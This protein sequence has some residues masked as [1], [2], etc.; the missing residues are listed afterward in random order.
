M[1]GRRLSG[2]WGRGPEVLAS[3]L[4]RLGAL[5][6]RPLGLGSQGVGALVGGVLGLGAL[7][8]AGA[9]SAWA[10]DRKEPEPKPAVDLELDSVRAYTRPEGEGS[11]L[12]FTDVRPGDWAFQALMNLVNHHGC[13][14]GLPGGRFEGRRA[15][16]RFEAAALLGACLERVTVVTDDLQALTREFAAELALTRGRA[17][18]LEARLGEL[19][20]TTFSTTTKLHMQA[21]FVVGAN[22]FSGTATALTAAN[23][24]AFGATT[25]SYDLQLTLDTSFKGNDLLRTKL[26][27]GNFGSSSF[28]GAGPSPLSQL[29][30][31]FQE[32]VGDPPVDG[33]DV[34]AVDRLYYQ[35]PLGAFTLTAGGLVGQDDMMALWPSVYPA[36]T[37]LDVFTMP[38]AAAAY[39]KAAGVGGGLWWRSGGL[40]ISSNYVAANGNNGNPA[41]GGLATSGAAGVGTVQVAYGA[42]QWALAVVYAHVANGDELI[43]QGTPLALASLAVPGHTDAFALAG[44]WQPANGGWWPSI[45]AG[46]GLNGTS[47]RGNDNPETPLARASQSWSVGVQW[48]DVG[49]QGNGL[50]LAVGQP[51]FATRLQGGA[52]PRD[53]GLIGEAW[54]K[55]Q[56]SDAVSVTPALFVLGRPLGQETP[57]GKS[58]RQ[59]G[60]LVKMSWRF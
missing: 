48:R 17:D 4:L 51:T 19:A 10:L 31:A 58:F 27:A 23:R 54:Y 14:S 22:G 21:T 29:E 16:S 52:T 46:W 37:V 55:V 44:Y 11:S 59:L 25:A 12:L 57:S 42:E 41:E 47:D 43:P 24:A 13:A 32:Y 39:N 20:A 28:G 33:S 2:G 60:G 35:V 45:S 50:G 6:L 56:L 7:A 3:G 30:V 9:D 38:G 49:L 36:E 1:V 5:A 26:R 40:S 18:G 34:V 8:V 15:L 53:G